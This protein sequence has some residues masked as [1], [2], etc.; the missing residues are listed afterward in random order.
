MKDVRVFVRIT[1]EQH[2]E[3]QS[4]ADSSERTISSLMRTGI[5]N[6]ILNSKKLTEIQA[7]IAR[8]LE[9]IQD[10]LTKLK[11]ENL[12]NN[13]V[14]D[15][16]YIALVRSQAQLNKINLKLISISRR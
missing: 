16:L 12:G 1:P 11:G 2:K 3:L 13:P 14:A 9:E 7:E 10:S 8:L 4:L 5:E 15:D 6:A